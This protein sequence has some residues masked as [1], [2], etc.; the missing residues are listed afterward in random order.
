MGVYIVAALIINILGVH[1]GGCHIKGC[2]RVLLNCVV[3][4]VK[5]LV[6]SVNKM[7]YF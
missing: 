3:L 4:S 6:D 5:I 1:D 2:T 7:I